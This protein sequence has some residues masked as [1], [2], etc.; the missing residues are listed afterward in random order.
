[1]S[2][3]LDGKVA[4]VTGS[5]SGIGKAIAIEFGREGAHVVITWHHDREGAHR[6]EREV[7]AGGG[8]CVVLQLDVRDP[9]EVHRLFRVTHDQLGAPD[10]LVNDAAACGPEKETADLSD[11][12]WDD[13]LKTDLYGPF[14][15]CREFIHSRR[16]AGG[17]GKIINI[18]SVHEDLPMYGYAAYDAAQGGLRN[19]TRTL[20]LELARDRINV[21]NIAPGMVLM[22]ESPGAMDDPAEQ[23]KQ[24]SRIP[25][26]RAAEPWEIG[27]LAVYLAS[28]DADYVSG[29]SFILDGGLMMSVGQGA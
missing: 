20:C 25:L 17:G 6:T 24:V 12:E 21:N 18:T 26:R 5:D 1:M 16:A 9:Q 2:G 11:A 27:R 7:Q 10:I 13:V 28:G 3:R 19:L 14:Y 8:R 29:Q 4:I 23:E 15:C 22:P